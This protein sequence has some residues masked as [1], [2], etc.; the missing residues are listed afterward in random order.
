MKITWLK[1]N[2]GWEKEKKESNITSSPHPSYITAHI[3]VCGG[4]TVHALVQYTIST[5]GDWK[6]ILSRDRKSYKHILGLKNE[7]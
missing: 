4:Q 7:V 6:F 5:Y 1:K 2:T 3:P